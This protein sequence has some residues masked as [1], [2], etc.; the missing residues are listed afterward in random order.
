MKVEMGNL[1]LDGLDQGMAV[2]NKLADA[3]NF[4]KTEEDGETANDGS[5]EEKKER[6]E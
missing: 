4:M 2:L 1:M 5:V 6:E 3:K